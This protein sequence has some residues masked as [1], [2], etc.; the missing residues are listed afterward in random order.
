[1]DRSEN[2]IELSKA[3]S[4]AQSEI[5]KAHKDSENP[6]F[7]SKYADLTSVWEACSEA[8]KNNDLCV[9]QPTSVEGDNVLV[10]TVLLHK[11]GEWISGKLLVK[12][13]KDGPQSLGSAITYARR[14][15]LSAMVGVC[16]EDDDAE[17]ATDR[18]KDKVCTQCAGVG[19]IIKGKEEYGGGYLCYKKKGGCGAKYDDNMNPVFDTPKKE[20]FQEISQDQLNKI[21]ELFN[22]YLPNLSNT[23]KKTFIVNVVK[24]DYGSSALKLTS[25]EGDKV[26]MA[27]QD[28]QPEGSSQPSSPTGSGGTPANPQENQTPG[29]DNPLP[30][31]PSEE[32]QRKVRSDKGKP[33]KNIS[34]SIPEETMERRKRVSKV[35]S[36]ISDRERA[37]YADLIRTGETNLIIPSL[38]SEEIEALDAQFETD[39]IYEAFLNN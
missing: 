22:K 33:R 16:P 20:H 12:P 2:I 9:L 25:G 26:I 1:M 29:P 8:L 14:Y 17:E 10:E 6:Y 19:M 11:S 13:E 34:P 39:R 23:E 18:T 28:I 5:N 30:T 37:F 35:W 7:K 21:V 3:F 27:L 15:A 36:A 38:G 4:K 24:R 32:K 31:E